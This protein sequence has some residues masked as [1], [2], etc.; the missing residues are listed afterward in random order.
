VGDHGGVILA[1][2]RGRA[3]VSQTV[4]LDPGDRRACALAWLGLC[5]WAHAEVRAASAPV[6]RFDG[7]AT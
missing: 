5:A 1:A 2:V 7:G 6:Q 3:V 4:E